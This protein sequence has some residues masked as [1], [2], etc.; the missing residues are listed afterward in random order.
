MEHLSKKRIIGIAMVLV[1]FVLIIAI[2][3]RILVWRG[4]E[5]LKP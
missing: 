2:S 3:I 1:A 5:N 4:L